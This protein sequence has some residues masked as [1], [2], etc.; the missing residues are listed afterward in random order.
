MV[1]G[2]ITSIIIIGYMAKE[3]LFS[4]Y[5]ELD[6]VIKWLLPIIIIAFSI[7][8]WPLYLYIGLLILFASPILIIAKKLSRS[9]PR[10][11]PPASIPRKQEA[12]KQSDPRKL[13]EELRRSGGDE[14]R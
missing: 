2:I 3:D 8:Y 4:G 10:I 6:S 7:A 14:S 9:L 11:P 5:G 12:R 1:L 13:L